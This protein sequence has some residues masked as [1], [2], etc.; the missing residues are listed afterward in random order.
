MSCLNS[1]YRISKDGEGTKSEQALDGSGLSL[2]L[3]YSSSCMKSIISC[4]FFASFSGV[5]TL[6]ERLV[7]EE[8]AVSGEGGRGM[9]KGSSAM[10]NI[11]SP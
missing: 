4:P 7:L 10:V 3:V 2:T 9:K 1:G 5:K 6:L 11:G 8:A